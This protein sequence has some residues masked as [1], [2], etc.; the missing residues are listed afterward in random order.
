MSF[1]V[2]ANEFTPFDFDELTDVFRES[3]GLAAYDARHRAR[4]ARGIIAENVNAAE[5]AAVETR[6]GKERV[7]IVRQEGIPDL[8]RPR[9]VRRVRFEPGS[10]DVNAG[11]GEDF[12]ELPWDRVVLVSCGVVHVEEQVVEEGIDTF[13]GGGEDE[14]P[15]RWR[16]SVRQEVRD[17]VLADVFARTTGPPDFVHFRMTP[18]GLVYSEILGERAA[19]NPDANAREASFENFRTVLA[20]VGRRAKKADV[21]PQTIA[22]VAD[23]LGWMSPPVDARFDDEA[24]F[25]AYNRWWLSKRFVPTPD[26]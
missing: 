26:R 11:F 15:L 5:A 3:L 13:T 20:I 10:L 9:T 4:R 18:Q 1:A 8:R 12:D 16:S 7:C 22:L 21:T 17:D 19:F 23:E 24:D 6:L 14:G 2:V 25:L